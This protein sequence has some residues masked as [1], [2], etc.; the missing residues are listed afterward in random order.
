MATCCV[1]NANGTLNGAMFG[2]S[3]FGVCERSQ[4]A[5]V[6]STA[7]KQNGAM[8]RCTHRQRHVQ[9]HPRRAAEG[10]E[11]RRGAGRVLRPVRD[12][13]FVCRHVVATRVRF[14]ARKVL[15]AE[16][17]HD[18]GAANKKKPKTASILRKEPGQRRAYAAASDSACPLPHTERCARARAAQTVV[19]RGA[20]G[21]LRPVHARRQAR[22]LCVNA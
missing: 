14:G 20:A 15:A 13:D 11:E 1:P 6:F 10:V 2:N 18:A 16:A 21:R 8:L 19:R 3:T 4:S 17:E 5:C 7:S 12:G 22:L 9:R